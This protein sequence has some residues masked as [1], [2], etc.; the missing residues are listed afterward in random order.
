MR[1][2]DTPF[3]FDPF[4]EAIRRDPFALYARARRE[5]PVWAPDGAP[6]VSI[7]RYDDIQ[8]ILRDPATWSSRFPPPPGFTPEDLPPSMLVTDP[9]EHTRLRGL[10]NQ[11][12]TPRMIRRLEPR[13]RE[14]A[15]ELVAAAV[16]R[17]DVDLVEA[18]TYPLPVIVIAE[19]IGIPAEDR[20]Q[21]K[22]WSDAAVENLGAVFMGP[23]PP[24]RIA[25]QRQ[26]RVAMEEYF[27]GLVE[28]RRHRPRED[29]LS[30][31]VAAELEGS[32]LSFDELL[33][34]LVLLLVAGNE[35]TTT[36]I[37]NAVLALL[38]HP[39]ALAAVRAQPELLPRAVEE[40]LRWSSPVQMDPRRA[41]RPAE[42]R[43]HRIEPGQIV[44]SWL[45]SANRDETVFERPE[46]FDV[47]RGDNRHLAFGFGPH[48]CLGASLATLE[49]EVALGV[50]LARTRSFARVDDAP[51]PLH[52][53]IV[54]RAVTK[55]PLA[56]E[57]A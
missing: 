4:D 16:A 29:L 41:T 7:F 39:R 28:D 42:I 55:L 43:G 25:R 10:V 54:F 18:L 21:F 26:V 24:E 40:V 32:R 11:A 14:I 8:A 46:E 9:P 31:L 19:I 44:L 45:G 23:L 53:S 57:P 13:M 3:S 36:L 17:G 30:G 33:A 6:V 12:F 35:T 52:P 34:M 51:L 37:G 22:E 5:H 47:T 20:A 50:L 1:A 56:L 15:E 27:R 2:N 48:Y 49:A 38:E